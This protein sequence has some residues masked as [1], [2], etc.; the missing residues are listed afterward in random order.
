MPEN[1]NIQIQ[2]DQGNVYYP[3]AKSETTFM[4]DGTTTVE[5][6]ITDLKNGAVDVK[7]K[8]ANAI[9]G[10]GVPAS[11]N[12]T[13]DQ[14][15]TKIGQIT[16]GVNTGDATAVAS[17]IRS[18]KSAYMKGAKVTGTQPVQST[19]AQTVTPGKTDIIKPAGIYDGAITIKGVPVDASK[20]LVG[21]TIAE[22]AGTLPNRS[23]ENQHMPSTGSTVW[24]GD[25]IFLQP[26]RGFYDGA[27]WVT[28]LATDVRPEY[29]LA[30]KKVL[31]MVGTLQPT[32][33]A[34][35]EGVLLYNADIKTES[36]PNWYKRK[37]FNIGL[38]GTY[39]IAYNASGGGPSSGT[40]DAVLQI[41]KNGQPYGPEVRTTGTQ[42]TQ[43]FSHDLYF[44][45]GET[46]ELW[47]RA[48]QS[49]SYFC[50]TTEYVLKINGA[51]SYSNGA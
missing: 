45:A 35:G 44:N 3:H 6:A 5:K 19:A 21:T 28:A 22:T 23:A 34:P 9:S 30:G 27:T 51:P 8:V 38:N 2:D 41:R 11:P 42:V 17:D 26:P 40:V 43:W 48:S 33:I 29:I 32:I 25:R 36:E 1:R 13:G 20:V 7:T 24:T 4:A 10:K 14:L 12:D 46:C 47:M 16:T 31:E 37:T 50:R 18:G 15:A 49:S 39:R